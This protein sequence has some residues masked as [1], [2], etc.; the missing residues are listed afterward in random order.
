MAKK[1]RLNAFEMCCPG[2]IQQGMWAH[3]RDTSSNYTTSEYWEEI[4]RV[5]ERGLFDGIFL[6]DVLGVY[7]VYKGS[8]DT[9]LIH[10]LQIPSGDPA[11]VIPLMS[12]VTKNIGFGLTANVTYE[13]P[14]LLAR[15]FSTLDHLT[16]G[17]VAWNIVTGY[18]DSGA[19]GMGRGGL[20]PHDDRYAYAEEFMD[21]VYKLWEGSWQDDAMLRDRGARMY[22][23]PTKVHKVSHH[24]RH[25][26]LNAIHLCEPSPQRTP[27][28]YQAGASDRG[29][30]FAIRHAECVFIAAPTKEVARS[31]VTDLRNEMMLSGRDP[32]DLM[33]F[34]GATIVA[35]ETSKEA[36][37][38]F[39]EYCQ[40]ASSEAALAHFSSSIGVDLSKYG[41]DEPIRYEDTNSNRGALE[42]ITVRSSSAWT[43]RRLMAS[44]R[45]GSRNQPIVGSA[46]DVADEMIAWA[47]ETGIDGFNLSR[48]V[49]PESL[50]DFVDLVVPVLQ[51][52]GAYK[53]CYETGTLRQK[54]FGGGGRLRSN[55]VGASFRGQHFV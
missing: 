21:V 33:I 32:N 8:S 9:A 5:A 34:I 2:F 37:Q 12:R 19:R 40:F 31:I 27:V 54:L 4:A 51:E 50:R 36:S 47:E 45:H 35:A 43:L 48:T 10:G 14:Y 3:P 49:A 18:L 15:R 39:E 20:A 26:A 23:D 24:G 7:D 29:R 28:L 38:K 22:V 55:H 42:S 11:L 1:I 52:R 44:M 41:M 46:T 13:A 30:K 17:R 25:F 16:D 6:A 53:T